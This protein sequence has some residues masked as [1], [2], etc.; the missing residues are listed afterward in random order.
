MGVRDDGGPQH[1]L[2]T[3]ELVFY[4]QNLKSLKVLD[5]DETVERFSVD[6]WQPR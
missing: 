1:G 5:D 3:S 4:V 2:V 6:L